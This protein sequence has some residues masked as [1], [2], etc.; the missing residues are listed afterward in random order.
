MELPRV[1]IIALVSLSTQPHHH[2][3]KGRKLVSLKIK[4]LKTRETTES[5]RLKE[6]KFVIVKT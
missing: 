6:Y 1:K 4:K 5:M 3:T 2:I